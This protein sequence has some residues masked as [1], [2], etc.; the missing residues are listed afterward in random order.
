MNAPVTVNQQ[1]TIETV[2][3]LLVHA[4]TMETEAAERYDELA[5]QM[6]VHNNDEV[7]ALFRKL[8]EIEANHIAAVDAMGEGLE[9]P[10]LKAWEFQWEGESP[11]TPDID[12]VHYLMKP[13]H[14]IKLALH[15]EKQAVRFFEDVIASS[16]NPK[17]REA[18]DKLADDEREHVALLE[19]Y[20]KTF[21]KPDDGWDD[22]M[23]P[24][25]LQE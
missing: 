10:D 14:A 17:L 15:H 25:N 11:E 20:L 22:D 7:A 3:Q 1:I 8:A 23:N 12:G 6:E 9:L 21:P 5:D 19:K 4:R 18:A 24:P 16:E 13:Y 2:E